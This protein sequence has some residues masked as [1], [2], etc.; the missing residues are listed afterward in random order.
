[1]P[2]SIDASRKIR[3]LLDMGDEELMAELERSFRAS[4]ERHQKI[5]ETL[6]EMLQEV[7]RLL[8]RIDE[9]ESDALE[10][11]DNDLGER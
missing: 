7:D 10:E 4:D 5:D 11:D 9:M 3:E 8:L 2:D 6:D 1:M